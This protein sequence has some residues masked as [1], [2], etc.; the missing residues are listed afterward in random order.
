M[1][2]RL[3]ED[4]SARI[5]DALGHIPADDCDTWLRVGMAIKAELGDTGFAIWDNWSR[6]ADNYVK[7]DAIDVWRSIRPG[8]GI[9]I[10][11]L[12]HLARRHGHLS[13]SQPVS[14]PVSARRQPP[15]PRRETS[16]YAADENDRQMVRTF[17][18]ALAQIAREQNAAVLLLAH[19]DKN[20]AKYGAAG[21][22]YSGSTAWH[23]SARSRL[24]L[25]DTSGRL[26]LHHEKANLSRR[27]DPIALTWTDDGVLIPTGSTVRDDLVDAGDESAVLA[28]IQA[29]L[30]DGADVP[31]A[32][33]GPSTTQHVLNTYPELP[34]ALRTA[35][36]RRRFWAAITQLQ[37]SGK[38]IE[39]TITTSARHKK[40]VWKCAGSS[41]M[42]EKS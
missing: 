10:G 8:G 32:R 9:G 19:I 24:A 20:A 25:T 4:T 28:A 34:D 33:T 3:T 1:R 22:S 16:A 11:T 36:G 35:K 14:R 15:A 26:E 5:T 13:D 31:T 41:P 27:I 30:A 39:T 40:K 6:T 42:G 17:M 7:R 23:N 37:R 29:A 12:F 21:N 38:I 18:R 2:A